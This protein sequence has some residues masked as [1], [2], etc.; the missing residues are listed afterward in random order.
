MFYRRKIILALMQ[1]FDGHLPK[2]SLQKLL[3][4]FANRQTK[5]DYDFVPYKYGCYSFSANADLTAMVKHGQILADQT[6]FTKIDL[7]DYVKTLNE[8]DKKIWFDIKTTYCKLTPNSL[9][10][11]TYLNYQYY[12][13]NSVKAKEILNEEQYDKVLK[14]KPINANTILY[15]IGYEGISLEEYLN[16]LIKNDVKVLVDVRNN[17]LS[18]K[19]GF[20]K[21]QL[22]TFCASLNIEYLHIP[23]VGIQ[24]NQ[25]QELKTQTDYDNLF[26]IYKTQNLKKT[27]SQQQEILNLLKM[28]KRIALTCFEANICQCHRKHLAE[29]II[30]LPEWNYELK[31]I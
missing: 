22:K 30:S 19:F 7:V 13:I 8:K 3:F 20:S 24:S 27:T 10:K 29:A 25:R 15:T 1:A 5:P 26:D 11:L 23:E 14:A 12:A 31:H 21:T 16:R 9:M 18:M 6:S 4:L 17:A 28:K 2:I